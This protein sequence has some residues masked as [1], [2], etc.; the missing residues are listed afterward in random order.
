MQVGYYDLQPLEKPPRNLKIIIT[1]LRRSGS[2]LFW[3]IFRNHPDYKCYDEPFNP[4]LAQLP[5]EHRKGVYHEFRDLINRDATGFWE[6]YE[7]INPVNECQVNLN[8]GQESYLRFLLESSE[9][10]VIDTTR[11]WN[12]TASL[13]KI[14][15]DYGD[16]SLLIYLH[17]SPRAFVSSHMLPSEVNAWRV[18]RYLKKTFW[19]RNDGF[20]YW[21]MEEVLGSQPASAFDTLVLKGVDAIKSEDYYKLP[22]YQKMLFFWKIVDEKIRKALDDTHINTI[23]I[24]FESYCARPKDVVREIDDILGTELQDYVIMPGNLNTGFRP[25]DIRWN[26]GVVI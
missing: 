10:V 13:I 6:N 12:K 5:T 22:A 21:K 9:H 17:R 4:N 26:K 19:S 1:T 14:L 7:P 20:N 23:S 16:Q 3:K 24:S 25:D 11:C 15:K 2:T 8:A 18:N